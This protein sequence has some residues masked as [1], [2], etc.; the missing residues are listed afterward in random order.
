M[1]CAF[2]EDGERM[3]KEER[4]KAQGKWKMEEARVMTRR[5]RFERTE[6][7][8]R[9]PCATERPDPSSTRDGKDTRTSSALEG[10]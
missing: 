7:P 8:I 9:L 2:C 3:S 4:N 1:V 5:T 10:R 6:N